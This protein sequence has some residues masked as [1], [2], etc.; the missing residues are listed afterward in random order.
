MRPRTPSRVAKDARTT[1]GPSGMEASPHNGR[2]EPAQELQN[3]ERMLDAADTPKRAPDGSYAAARAQKGDIVVAI[4]QSRYPM[5]PQ[6]DGWQIPAAMREY[7]LATIWRVMRSPKANHLTKIRAVEALVKLDGQ[8]LASD[9]QEDWKAVQQSHSNRS[10]VRILAELARTKA[11]LP[12]EPL[13]KGRK[14]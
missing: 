2:Q 12:A 4:G 11:K 10:N 7:A 6:T 3:V 5:A 14:S 1:Y 9:R 13:R 8:A